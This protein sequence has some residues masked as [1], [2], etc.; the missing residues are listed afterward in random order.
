MTYDIEQQPRVNKT[1]FELHHS[2]DTVA[3][4][5]NRIRVAL[6]MSEM[7]TDR[8]ETATTMDTVNTKAR[9]NPKPNPKPKQAM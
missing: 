5:I 8:T 9:P 6:K 7:A 2:N 3:T 1:M 4:P